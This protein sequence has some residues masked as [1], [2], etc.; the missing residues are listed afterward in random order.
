MATHKD[1]KEIYSLEG[2]EVNLTA[3]GTDTLTTS[4][5]VR[6]NAGKWRVLSHSPPPNYRALPKLSHLQAFAHVGPLPGLLVPF[7]SSEPCQPRTLTTAWHRQAFEQNELIKP[8]QPP[9]EGKIAA[10]IS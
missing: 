6:P 1:R 4:L 7:F 3:T 9:P 10:P 8:S 2:R 5:R